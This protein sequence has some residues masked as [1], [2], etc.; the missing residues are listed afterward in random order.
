M[1]IY[2]K[3][4]NKGFGLVELVL[5]IGIFAIIASTLML[6]VVDSTRT[7]ENTKARTKASNLTKEIN[8]TLIMLKSK[9]W[10]SVAS[11][12][13]TGIKHF[14]ITGG[15][16]Q[17]VNGQGEKNGF[18][19]TIEVL[20]AHRDNNG[21][22]VESGG[23]VDAHT[24]LVQLNIEWTDS[25]EKVHSIS[26]MIYINDWETN[27]IVYTT[28]DDFLLGT[29]SSTMAANYSGGEIRLQSMF[30]ADWCNPTLS[31]TSHDLPGQGIASNVSVY[32]EEVHM[33]T[34]SN[35]SGISF[36]KATVAGEPPTVTVNGT[37]DG[38]KVNDVFGI[39]NYAV[40]ATDNNA[41]EVVIYDITT[42]PFTEV[43]YFNATGVQDAN[44]VFV[45]GNRGFVAHGN[46][47]SI[48][49][50]SSYTGERALIR[51]SNVGA[52]TDIFVEGVYAYLTLSGNNN[53]FVI[54]EYNDSSITLR[55]NAD[56]NDADGTSL[57]I[58]T[59]TNRA[60]VTTTINIADEFFI[61]N[62]SNK[63]GALPVISSFDTGE[64][65][66][67]AVA[68]IDNRAI[69]AGTNGE[70]YQVLDI[71]N[72]G[73]PNKCG[74]LQINTGVNALALVK[75]GTN[76]YTYVVTKDST[77]EFKIIRGGPGGG[78][79]DGNGY[80]PNGEYLSPIFDSQST[81]ST[82]FILGLTST[83][84][85]GT[86]LK[87]QIRV[88]INSD[89]SGSTWLGPDGTATTY[90]TTTNV[91]TLPSGVTGR[92]LQ[93]K[94]EL[95]SDTVSTPLLEEIVINYEK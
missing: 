30:Y 75:Q 67:K 46:S 15:E 87:V 78:G 29:H 52:A 26:P 86:T 94:A 66:P 84:P 13:N 76:H 36:M 42:S 40:L 38:Y 51:S 53:Q 12:T 60:Y 21:V 7:L 90:F 17:I 93:Y 83:V 72:E 25:L 63:V 80:L 32:G 82:Y 5:A 81:T 19:Y 50:L 61:V 14:E 55:G 70:E 73:A 57:Y 8:S 49:D 9:S 34:G 3:N 20:P 92:Y 43:G 39:G 10:Y 85:S 62:I 11:H 6:L 48:F 45:L 59:V 2:K 35:S 23:T 54:Y 89:M 41:K 37:I 24:R 69:I 91:Y 33:G 68:S 22:L 18:T 88:S 64:M 58:S 31:M 27:S 65:S 4:N 74:G 44:S 47:L 28:H 79:A 71:T 77:S 1:K 95:I 16:Y 56:L